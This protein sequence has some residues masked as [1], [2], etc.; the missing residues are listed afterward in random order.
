MHRTLKPSY[1]GIAGITSRTQIEK[2]LSLGIDLG[3]RRIMM[4][5][6]ANTS[7]LAG[8]R[9]KQYPARYPRADQLNKIFYP[10][11]GVLNIVHFQSER[12]GKIAQ[13]LR[14]ISEQCGELLHGF[15]INNAWPDAGEL[16]S[17][18]AV[19]PHHRIVLQL[20]RSVLSEPDVDKLA[21]KIHRQYNDAVHYLLIDGSQGTGRPIDITL[22]AQLIAALHKHAPRMILG[23]AGGLSGDTIKRIEPLTKI[24][25]NLCWDAETAL[26]EPDDSALDLSAIRRYLLASQ[27]MIFS[28]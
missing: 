13:Q 1:V 17:H 20:N 5:V 15:Q 19:F 23:V 16:W 21:H 28:D 7:T 4:G 14:T 12:P 26:R 11:P 6:L 10:H 3:D 22:T 25:P 2:I 18:R 24:Y 9:S 8:K 27:E